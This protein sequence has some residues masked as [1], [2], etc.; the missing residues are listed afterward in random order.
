MRIVGKQKDYYDSAMAYGQD[1][2]VVFVRNNVEIDVDTLDETVKNL[3]TSQTRIST[4]FFDIE[5]K[6]RDKQIFEFYANKIVFCGKTYRSIT[7]KR[8]FSVGP[9]SY[10]EHEIKVFY[11]LD[12]LKSYLGSRGTALT[13]LKNDQR[14][15]FNNPTFIY[16]LEVFLASQA[17]SELEEFCITN[18]HVILVYA[19][20]S[21][22]KIVAD[23]EKKL[24]SN[25]YLADFQFF[26]MFESFAAYQELDMFVSGTLPQS[27]VPTITIS[28]KDKI[29]KHGFDKFSFRK[30]PTK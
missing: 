8:S 14:N 16:S 28:D 17:T 3:I 26:R 9:F 12:T 13:L 22:F 4:R 25:G 23:S 15:A 10:R 21:P 11:E 5:S 20:M 29:R 30:M 7:V 18:R 19:D 1:K 2:S 6:D 27:T 24:V